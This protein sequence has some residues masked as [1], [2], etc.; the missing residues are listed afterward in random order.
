MSV[1]I[2]SRS[3]AFAGPLPSRVTLRSDSYS[4]HFLSASSSLMLPAAADAAHSTYCRLFIMV[5]RSLTI[6]DDSALYSSRKE[7]RLMVPRLPLVFSR[8]QASRYSATSLRSCSSSRLT[9]TNHAVSPCLEAWLDKLSIA[10]LSRR[11]YGLLIPHSSLK[12]HFWQHLHFC[13]SPLSDGSNL[14]LLLGRS[15]F[16]APPPATWPNDKPLDAS[17]SAPWAWSTRSSTATNT[18]SASS[19][20]PPGKRRPPAGAAET[21][22][23]CSQFRCLASERKCWQARCWLKQISISGGFVPLSLFAGPSPGMTME[24]SAVASPCPSRRWAAMLCWRPP[25]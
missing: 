3:G 16:G 6:T 2:K 5:P 1:T 11:Q 10:C 7:T 12:N 24:T 13:L 14:I 21:Q 18:S 20:M 22:K 19:D 25:P 4:L 8:G 15:S 23:P 9:S 17:S